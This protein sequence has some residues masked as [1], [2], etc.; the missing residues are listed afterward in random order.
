MGTERGTLTDKHD[1]Q[2]RKETKI[3]I[4]SKLTLG[5]TT[6]TP[7][8][9]SQDLYELFSPTETGET[10][11]V[12]TPEDSLRKYWQSINPLNKHAIVEILDIDNPIEVKIRGKTP[13]GT[14]HN[15]LNRHEHKETHTLRDRVHSHN[16]IEVANI[17]NSVAMMSD[18]L[19]DGYIPLRPIMLKERRGFKMVVNGI[20]LKITF[21]RLQEAG[22][23][24]I[25]EDF[26]D[27]IEIEYNGKEK[28]LDKK[29]LERIQ[30]QIESVT[31]DIK[32]RFEQLGYA[33][34][35]DSPSKD[36]WMLEHYGHVNGHAKV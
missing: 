12:L 9:I 2:P 10:L 31:S 27:Q 23:V 4:E 11:P 36:K 16:L 26:L 25:K 6:K 28:E 3:E 32:T 29:T 1:G 18:V 5:R 13:N 35:Q 30:L 7:E 34:Q 17:F 14:D 21:D 15:I 22:E 24:K 20:P 33:F 19:K 8:Q